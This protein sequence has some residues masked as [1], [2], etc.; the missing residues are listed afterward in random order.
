MSWQQTQT[1]A[2]TFESSGSLHLTK[3]LRKSPAKNATG[4]WSPC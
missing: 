3:R 4:H 2:A 1:P